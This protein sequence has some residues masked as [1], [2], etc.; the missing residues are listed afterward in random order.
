MARTY[1]SPSIVSGMSVSDIL[2]MDNKTFNSLTESEMRKVV[3]R[4]V[5]AGNKRLRTFEKR[6]ITSPA[7]G[8]V[9]SSGG[10]FSTKGKDLNALRAEYARARSFM[11][12]KTGT[13]KQWKKVKEQTANAMQARGVD[14][15][16]DKLEDLLKAYDRLKELDPTIEERSLKYKV[17]SETSDA[18]DQMA[19]DLSGEELVD[20][21][22]RAM[23]DEITNIYEEEREND[24]E[25]V[26]SFFEF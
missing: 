17:M 12:S 4:L 20:A 25:D 22:V 18:L 1:K 24:A 10:A 19:E 2:N 11:K 6:G 26:S 5:S 8:A 23:Q 14:V 16:P 21:V 15:D 13:V 7:A 9:R 3:G